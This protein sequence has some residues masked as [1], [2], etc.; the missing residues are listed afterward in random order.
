MRLIDADTLK[1][2]FTGNFQDE[3]CIAQI[4]AMIDIRP[5]VEFDPVRHGKW[6]Q[7][8]SIRKIGELNIPISKCSCCNFSFCDIFNSDEF[9]SFCPNCGARMDV[10]EK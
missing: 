8:S 4:K 9:Y 1:A 10:T 6:K 2:E 5:T 3:Y 7:I